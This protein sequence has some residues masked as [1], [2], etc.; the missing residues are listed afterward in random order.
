MSRGV[1]AVLV[2]GRK[3]RSGG[4]MARPTEMYGC[5]I[6]RIGAEAVGLGEF[7]EAAG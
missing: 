3:W 2:M 6:N 5:P 4:V 1:A 7:A